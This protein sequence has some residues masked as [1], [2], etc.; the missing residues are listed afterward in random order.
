[1]QADRLEIKQAQTKT[2]QVLVRWPEARSLQ[3]RRKA[4]LQFHTQQGLTQLIA[5]A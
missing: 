3:M 2:T 5:E 1:M 4:N